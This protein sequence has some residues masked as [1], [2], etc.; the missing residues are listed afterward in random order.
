MS[1]KIRKGW[2]ILICAI[3][4]FVTI[5]CELPPGMYALVSNE[6]GYQDPNSD[7]ESIPTNTPE[8]TTV[9]ELAPEIS[10]PE[11][12][13]Q[14]DIYQCNALQEVNITVEMVEY[15]VDEGHIECEYNHNITITGE[16][17]VWI[18]YYKHFYY[19]TNPPPNEHEF[20]WHKVA[21]RQPREIWSL[22]SFLSDCVKCTP[23][24][25]ESIHLSIA[26]VYDNPACSWI[27]EGT[28]PH[29]DILQIAEG[30]PILSPCTMIS[31]VS[32][33]SAMPDIYE[34]LRK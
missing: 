21:P 7:T 19:G 24:R 15:V 10:V 29:F 5:T 31:P 30:E 17:P 2:L 9:G 23:T 28:Q 4:S 1:K 27:T 16:Q 6:G 18:I 22:H 14:W 3:A 8:D 25:F 34:G 13:T 20:G 11:D 26:A 33:S 12:A 32:Y